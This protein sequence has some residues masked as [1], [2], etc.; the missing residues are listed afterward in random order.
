MT[1][2]INPGDRVE[3]VK[4]PDPVGVVM[5]VR[6][7]FTSDHE[8]HEYEV[9]FDGFRS[10]YRDGELKKVQTEMFPKFLPLNYVAPLSDPSRIG[11]VMESKTRPDGSWI[12]RVVF[13]DRVGAWFEEHLIRKVD[14]VAKPPHDIPPPP[15]KLGSIVRLK[16]GGPEMTLLEYVPGP[17]EIGTSLGTVCCRVIWFV[18]G[19][20][21]EQ[22]LPLTALEPA[23]DVSEKASVDVAEINSPATIE[24]QERN[25]ILRIIDKQIEQTRSW[26]DAATEVMDRIEDHLQ[27]E[28]LGLQ[29]KYAAMLQVLQIIRNSIKK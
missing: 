7:Q 5:C 4:N 6:T 23:E 28:Q 1:E 18:D 29:F 2:E 25:R 12:Y 13:C 3:S 15:I 26:K 20:I 16:S 24:S 19:T 8:T 9:D 14:I 10:G 22:T 21:R 17:P 27:A 11:Q